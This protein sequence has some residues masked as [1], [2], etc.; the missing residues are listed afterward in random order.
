MKDNLSA[1]AI[2]DLLKNEFYRIS[3]V[4]ES[5]STNTQVREVALAGKRAG[6]VLIAD[7]QT[8]GRGRMGRTFHSPAGTGLYLSLLLRPEDLGE[9]EHM[10]VLC[11]VA[12]ARAVNSALGID[13]G[14]KWVNDLY[15]RGKKVCGILAESALNDQGAPDYV[16][17]GVGFNVFPPEEGFPQEIASLAGALCDTFDPT[18]RTRLAAAFL[19]EFSWAMMEDFSSL[20]EEYRRRSVLIGKSVVS[21]SGGFSGTATVLGIDIDG[22]LM[23]RLENGKILGLSSGEVRVRL[24]ETEK[25]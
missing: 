5:P 1:E 20:M 17:C 21:L 23:V 13:V 16:I 11:A 2:Q 10:T 12:A 25:E 7:R 15:Y 8:A 18:A 22:R 9:T 19:K 6:Y 3:V 4:E 14:I 24:A